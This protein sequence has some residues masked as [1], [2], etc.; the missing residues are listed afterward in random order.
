MKL[1]KKGDVIEQIILYKRLSGVKK[2]LDNLNKS[3]AQPEDNS[4]SN[5][6]D[7]KVNNE[8]ISTVVSSKDYITNNIIDSIDNAL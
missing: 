1:K 5:N 7:D 4:D 8:D 6:C 2:L 3:H